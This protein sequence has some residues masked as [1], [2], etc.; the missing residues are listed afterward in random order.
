MY[1]TDIN[2]ELTILISTNIVRLI[3]ILDE[4]DKLISTSISKIKLI[5]LPIN[6]KHSN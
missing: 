2:I 6:D 5:I 1:S 4:I 3:T